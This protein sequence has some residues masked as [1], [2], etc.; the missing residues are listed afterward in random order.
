MPDDIAVQAK[1]VLQLLG[2][3]GAYPRTDLFA[4]L[5][6]IAPERVTDALSS[7]VSA[8]VVQLDTGGVRTTEPVRRLDELGLIAL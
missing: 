7:L 3:G 6:G 2:R 1:V 4:A 5:E 8:G